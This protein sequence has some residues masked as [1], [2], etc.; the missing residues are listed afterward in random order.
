MDITNLVGLG[1]ACVSVYLLALTAALQRHALSRVA[2]E[3]ERT[4]RWLGGLSVYFLANVLY[5]IALLFTPASLLASLMALV[6][7]LNACTS[8]CVLGE[9]QEAA[10]V[11]GGVLI[12]AGIAVA[13][14][15]APYDSSLLTADDVESMLS[16]PKALALLLSLLIAAISIAA[17]I[18]AHERVRALP[19]WMADWMPFAYPIVVGLCESLVQVAQK[20]GIALLAR[21]AVGDER[22]RWRMIADHG[23][24]VVATL[25]GWALASAAT[26]YWLRKAL[27][28]LP[29]SRLLPIEYGTFTLTSV[30]A[31]LICYDEARFVGLGQ[32]QTIGF[33]MVLVLVGCALVGSRQSLRAGC[34]CAAEGRRVV[35]VSDEALLPGKEW[36]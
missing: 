21:L 5:T 11:Q 15:A 4:C 2:H 26:I 17:S 35:G 19:V 7:P 34:V 16:A 14:W 27:A 20:G 1:L 9:R 18:L 12:T 32:L 3:P 8:A 13:A 24:I 25:G 30:L 22:Q 31:G 36:L 33:A 10:D 6:V 23:L 28:R 29:A